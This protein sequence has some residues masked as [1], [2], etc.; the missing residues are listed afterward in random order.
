MRSDT[1]I[2]DRAVRYR[3]GGGDDDQVGRPDRRPAVVH[4]L[5]AG[6]RSDLWTSDTLHFWWAAG[7]GAALTSTT[8][9]ASILRFRP[10]LSANGGLGLD[11]LVP[12]SQF[13]IVL[14]ARYRFLVLGAGT[15][16]QSEAHR[17]VAAD[18]G[19]TSALLDIHHAVQSLLLLRVAL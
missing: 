18:R 5:E 2:D 13:A 1:T 16:F 6:L 12:N 7:G 17:A 3:C 8:R 19:A 14:E 10:G 4:R 11:I 9:D 15:G